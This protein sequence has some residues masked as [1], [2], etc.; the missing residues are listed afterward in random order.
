MKIQYNVTWL[1]GQISRKI[2]WWK[3]KLIES[4]LWYEYF[5]ALSR[6]VWHRYLIDVDL[7]DL[8]I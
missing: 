6:K 2:I 3:D 7:R 1:V 5:V 8:A 4:Y